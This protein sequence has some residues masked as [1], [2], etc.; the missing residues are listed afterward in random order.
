M[1]GTAVFYGTRGPVQTL[2]DYLEASETIDDFLDG[3]PSVSHRLP[4]GS[5]GPTDR[6]G[7]VRV[8]LGECIDWCLGREFASHHV[9]TASNGPNLLSAIEGTPPGTAKFTGQYYFIRYL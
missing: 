1:G 6:N 9:R 4:R 7:L 3:F 2:L 5:K 8:L